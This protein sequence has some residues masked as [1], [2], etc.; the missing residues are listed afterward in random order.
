MGCKMKFVVE[1]E[2]CNLKNGTRQREGKERHVKKGMWKWHVEWN[3]EMAC[4]KGNVEMTCE[5]EN[6]M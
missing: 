3:V 6:C 2:K 4:E 1:C 5:K